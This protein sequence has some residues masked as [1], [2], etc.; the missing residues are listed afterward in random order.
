M[1][2]LNNLILISSSTEPVLNA[3]DNLELEQ[4]LLLGDDKDDTD[5]AIDP[6]SFVL[7]F[8][9]MMENLPVDKEENA[10]LDPDK[11]EVMNNTDDQIIKMDEGSIGI[12]RS[13]IKI[14]NQDVEIENV[15]NTSSLMLDNSNKINMKQEQESL[16]SLQNNVAMA[17]INSKDYQP[18]QSQ[19]VAIEIKPAV[20]A[21]IELEEDVPPEL[22]T[23]IT[24]SEEFI[25]QL[26]KKEP[27]SSKPILMASANVV[28][29]KD[30]FVNEKIVSNKTILDQ[31]D[32]DASVINSKEDLQKILNSLTTQVSS[33]TSERVTSELVQRAEIENPI[34]TNI[35]NVVQTGT[36]INHENQNSLAA[37]DP[38]FFDIPVDINNSQWADKFSEHIVWFGNQ[39]I[40]SAL[41]KISPDDLGPIEISI[42]VIKDAA[43]VNINS[44]SSHVRDIVDQAIPKLREMMAEQGLSLSDVHIGSETS[45][46]QFSQNN[47]GS[48]DGLISSSE[49]EVQITQITKRVQQGLIDYFA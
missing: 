23:Q 8:T 19:S 43:S 40:K 9:Q 46:R 3:Q 31:P 11:T 36:L 42:K 41:I 6:S 17:W 45:S 29:D 4:S 26:L 15:K 39:G 25:E 12:G 21:E 2:D 28:S 32:N 20:T 22:E 44:H 35:Q 7:L 49:D 1:L 16:N 5:N 33:T 38:K 27:A 34:L 18:P 10:T 24:Q 13:D 47:Q 30:K 14:Q 48:G 37:A